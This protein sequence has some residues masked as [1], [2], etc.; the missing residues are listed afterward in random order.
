M[1]ATAQTMPYGSQLRFRYYFLPTMHSTSHRE[2]RIGREFLSE[3]ER[4]AYRDLG[5]ITPIVRTS[6]PSSESIKLLLCLVQCKT[7][8]KV[9]IVI[10]RQ[11]IEVPHKN[12][13]LSLEMMKTARYKLFKEA[14]NWVKISSRTPLGNNWLLPPSPS[15]EMRYLSHMYLVRN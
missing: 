8:N 10:F 9:D 12:H 2:S 7:V 11:L 4:M 1:T 6:S 3:I 13:L 15:G 5:L 14:C